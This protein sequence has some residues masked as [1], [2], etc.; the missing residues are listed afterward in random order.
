MLSAAKHLRLL[1]SR[2]R[3]NPNPS[4]ILLANALSC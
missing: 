2:L 4:Q 3:R 1:L